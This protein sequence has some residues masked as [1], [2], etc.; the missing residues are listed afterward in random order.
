MSSNSFM[1]LLNYNKY[2]RYL[3]P[4]SPFSILELKYS[5]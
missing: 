4:T 5:G 3:L 2:V 1:L